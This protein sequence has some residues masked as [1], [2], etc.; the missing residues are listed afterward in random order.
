MLVIHQILSN[1]YLA[2][3]LFTS[4]AGEL[5]NSD[6]HASELS[7]SGARVLESSLPCSSLSVIKGGLW[8]QKFPGVTIANKQNQFQWLRTVLIKESQFQAVGRESAPGGHVHGNHP[9]VCGTR[10]ETGWHCT[11]CLTSLVVLNSCLKPGLDNFLKWNLLIFIVQ[12]WK[13]SLRNVK[14]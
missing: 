7:Q 8:R 2:W 5:W 4:S 9:R 3:F 10:V 14:S 6:E 12:I 13:L 1:P 11:E